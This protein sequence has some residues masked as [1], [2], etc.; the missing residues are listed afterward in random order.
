MTGV[1]RPPE[2]LCRRTPAR[3]AVACDAGA[4]PG[5]TGF[6]MDGP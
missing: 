4:V 2:T 6:G 3:A 1:C 5:V